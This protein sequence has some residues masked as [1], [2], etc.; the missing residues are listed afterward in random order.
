[1]QLSL[2]C[3]STITTLCSSSS[4]GLK[5]LV[6]HSPHTHTAPSYPWYGSLGM[7]GHKLEQAQEQANILSQRTGRVI[8]RPWKWLF[9]NVGFSK[10]QKELQGSKGD[11]SPN[12]KPDFLKVRKAIH[13]VWTHCFLMQ[14]QTV[15]SNEDKAALDAEQGKRGQVVTR[16]HQQP[17]QT[18]FIVSWGPG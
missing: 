10:S 17:Y 16:A 5:A 8:G 6:C 4:S 18:C 7:P 12:I 1:M 3:S 11:K 14:Y 13:W 9:F 2:L 15:P